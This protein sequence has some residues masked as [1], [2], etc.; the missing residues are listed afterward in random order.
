MI[1]DPE[2]K[3]GKSV[4]QDDSAVG[5]LFHHLAK[6]AGSV[7]PSVAA[8]VLG[9]WIVA[10]Y[11]NAK[12]KTK[13]AAPAAAIVT[14]A[15]PAPQAEAPVLPR[16][17]ATAVQVPDSKPEQRTSATGQPAKPEAIRVIPL[18]ATPKQPVELPKR[19]QE[20]PK[21]VT[22][23]EAVKKVPAEPHLARPESDPGGPE[24]ALIA[25]ATVGE[26]DPLPRKDA[27][28]IP[29]E[30]AAPKTAEDAL[31]VA[32]KALDRLKEEQPVQPVRPDDG[33]SSPAIAR[34]PAVQPPVAPRTEAKVLPPP[35]PPA[36]VLA[37]PAPP[38]DP[39]SAASSPM[40]QS[41]PPDPD[42]PVPP[43][44][45][46]NASPPGFVLVR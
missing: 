39:P 29:E 30:T 32:R 12:P 35:L 19:V 8:T 34:T 27:A 17:R 11:I 33:P 25:P 16:E 1:P 45:I 9:A 21:P 14:S 46:P 6:F 41:S 26:P 13:S 23:K 15:A 28:R 4:D 36:V 31:E 2:M 20:G 5:G 10:N 42:R 38:R 44:D 37:D 18:Q 7:V 3:I 24:A 22:K 40:H 43:A